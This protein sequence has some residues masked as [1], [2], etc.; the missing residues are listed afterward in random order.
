MALNFFS[1][2]KSDDAESGFKR[3]ERKARRFFEH[4]QTVA[5]AR[6]YDY[7]IECYVNGLKHDPDN[8]SKHEALRDVSLRR[9]VSGGKPAGF[10]EKFKSGGPSPLDKM[11]HNEMLWA[12]DPLNV[13]LMQEVMK[14]AVE[15]DEAEPDL[16]LAEVA[17][18]VGG[19]AMDFNA[20]AKKPKKAVYIQIRD[21]FSRIQAFDKAVEACRHAIRLDQNNDK[22]LKD[23]KELE[24]EN[25]MQMGGYSGEQKTEEGGFRR[26]VRDAEKQRDLETEDSAR[27]GAALDETIKRRKAELEED[28][29]DVDKI[30]KIVDLLLRKDEEAAENEAI[31]MLQQLW[32]QTSQSR[33]KM[34]IGD[35]R[36]KQFNRRQRKLRAALEQDPDDPDLKQK[37]EELRRKRLTFELQEYRERVKQYPTDMALRFELGRRLYQSGEVDEAIGAFQQSKADPK[38]R[39]LSHE[40]LG[41]CYLHKGWFEEAVDT[42]RQGIEAHPAD[43]DRV[44]MDMRYLLMDALEKSARKNNDAEQA[45]EAQKLASQILQAD[46]NFRD[47]RDRMEGIRKLADELGAKTA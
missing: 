12:K 31:Q 11:L 43:S 1:Q 35:I 36:M 8:M 38:H 47:I 16:H 32:D 27:P 29:Q 22:L 4:A 23:L 25:T 7:A 34:R 15:A 24:A 2:G 5:D 13:S 46:I 42:L 33:Y 21:L 37:Y 17:Y 14:W 28:P 30:T 10:T 6:N 41:S 40:F 39:A 3:D 26:F 19:L 9:K 20:Q 45:R 44:A 18:W